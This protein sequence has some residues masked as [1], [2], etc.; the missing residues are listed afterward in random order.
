MGWRKDIVL[1]AKGLEQLVRL[2]D[3]KNSEVAA[4]KAENERLVAQNKDLLDR[5]MSRNFEEL[6]IYKR[7]Q[8]FEDS[9]D[10]YNPLADEDLIGTEQSISED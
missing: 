10:P 7:E 6:T 9:K 8:E 4:L 1:I 3:G 5:F 2:V